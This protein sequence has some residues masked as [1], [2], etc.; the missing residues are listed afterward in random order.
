MHAIVCPLFSPSPTRL[1]SC[2][3]IPLTM[4]IKNQFPPRGSAGPPSPDQH[5]ADGNEIS[6]NIFFDVIDGTCLRFLEVKSF[7]LSHAAQVL[8]MVKLN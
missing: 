1:K 7:P 3:L 4:P 6:I 8:E 5:R 2:R